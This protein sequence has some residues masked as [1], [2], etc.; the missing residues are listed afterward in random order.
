MVTVHA[1]GRLTK[2]PEM[3]GEGEK[4]VCVFPIAC[5]VPFLNEKG[6]YTTEFLNCV[7]FGKNAI[8][9][10]KYVVKGSLVEITGYPLTRTYEVEQ[11]KRKIT[12]YYVVDVEFLYSPKSDSE[13]NSDDENKE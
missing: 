13:S 12:Q 1:T 2:D 7:A 5:K 3:R 9:I 11:E 10:S 6:Q 8:N 4:K